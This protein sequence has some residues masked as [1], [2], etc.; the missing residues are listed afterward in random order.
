MERG[1]GVWVNPSREG[2]DAKKLRRT[3][4]PRSLVGRWDWL[5]TTLTTTT[6]TTAT[7]TTTL[8]ITLTTMM[9]TSY[10]FFSQ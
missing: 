7:L 9:S 1:Q 4:Q 5:T 6:A 2:M 3:S 10:Y 8:N